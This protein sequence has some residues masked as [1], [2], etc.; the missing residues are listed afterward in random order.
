MSDNIKITTR[1]GERVRVTFEGIYACDAP[2]GASVIAYIDL[3]D[4]T[5]AVAPKGATVEVIE[6]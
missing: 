6:P 1:Q 3:D 4:G 5:V 2:D